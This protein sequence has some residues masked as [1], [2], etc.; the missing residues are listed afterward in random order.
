MIPL[1]DDNSAR[2]I[3]PLATYALIVLNL[4]AFLLELVQP[5][6]E[7]FL[8]EWGTV[9]AQITAGQGLVTLL[10]S[11][12]L[13]AG[14][15]HLIGN[16]TFLW[17]FGDNVEDA[18]GHG[19]YLLFY[20]LCGLAASLA[21]VFLTPASTLPGVGASG[22]ISGLLAAYVIMFGS[23]RVRVMMG[24]GIGTVPAY[25]MIGLWIVFQFVNGLAAFAETAQTGG[26]AY[27]AHIGGF[28]AGL[29]LT[30]ALRGLA[31]ERLAGPAR[32]SRP[33]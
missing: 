17:I 28:V 27:G 1:G 12:F 32:P 33:R 6:I 7:R 21:Q 25:V 10:T 23:N 5:N 19:L 20:L 22:A 26:V 30:V 18:F 3:V 29:L 9:P 4:L 31:G 8:T 24:G 11:I 14:W 2:R 16:M 13:H 15:A